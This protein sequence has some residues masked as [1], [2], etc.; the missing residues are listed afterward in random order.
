MAMGTAEITGSL[1]AE[2]HNNGVEVTGK[3]S[4][5][6]VTG[7]VVRDT[8]ADAMALTGNGIALDTGGAATVD[9]STI[10]GSEN[11][12]LLVLDPGS[13][14][15]VTNSVVRGTSPSGALVGMG[16]GAS[17]GG[18]L[19]LT[20]VAIANTRDS[21]LRVQDK[22]SSATVVG[23]LVRDTS[24]VPT[25]QP[26]DGVGASAVLRREARAHRHHGGV[27]HARRRQRRRKRS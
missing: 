4:A 14:L 18:T 19:L 13:K 21:G 6:T 1:I 7:S 26:G 15:T 20:N 5:V 25:S 12:G 23:S 8:A 3:G 10:E 27:E 16:A 17:S 11:F 24:R 22:G 9:S 2:N